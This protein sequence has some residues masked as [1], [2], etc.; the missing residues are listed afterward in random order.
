MPYYIYKAIDKAGVDK[1]G[2]VVADTKDDAIAR[3]KEWGLYPTSLEEMGSAVSSAQ[4][5]STKPLKKKFGLFKP[6]VKSKDV[7]DFIRDLAFLIEGGIPLIRCLR[8]ISE[9]TLREGPRKMVLD[10]ANTVEQGASLSDALKKYPDEFPDLYTSMI[11]AGEMGGGKLLAQVLQRLSD[12]CENTERLRAKIVAAL[13]YP[14]LVLTFALCV[15]F[16]LTIF[17]IPKFFVIYED[18]DLKLPFLT[19]ALFN[20]SNFLRHNILLIVGV[21]IAI[22]VGFRYQLKNEKFQL[23]WDQ[24]KLKI[25][26]LGPLFQKVAIA[27]FSRTLGTLVNSGVPILTALDTVKDTTGNRSIRNAIERVKDSVREGESLAQPLAA[28]GAFPSLVT[29]TVAIGEETGDLG[30]ILIK[31][32][33]K[34]DQDIETSIIQLTSLIEPILIVSLGIIIGFIVI[35]LFFP[36][37][38]LMQQLSV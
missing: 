1:T 15:V 3:V 4:S 5:T 2:T 14:A 8:V 28:S 13:T 31:I 36:L 23:F 26:V 17:V 18:L 9:Q 25:P 21:G 30:N 33:D 7:I 22:Y 6:S 29:N 11:Y 10:M 20:T 16:A 37:V 32:G 24:W 12:L 38:S 35:A 34:F 19:V 27:R